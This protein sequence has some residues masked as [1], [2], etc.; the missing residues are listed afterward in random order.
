MNYRSLADLNQTI[1]SNLHKI[2]RDS[3]LVVGIPRSGLLAANI[4][5]LHRNRPLT[6][7]DG[8][9]TG[10]IF[11][12]GR[13]LPSTSM[14][15]MRKV[16]VIDDSINSG[17][18]IQRVK[19][20][21]STKNKDCDIKYCAIY[22]NS[23]ANDNVDYIFEACPHPRVFEWNLLNSCCLSN[24][25]MDID[26]V[27]CRDPT[28]DE[29]D[30]GIRY[31]EFLKSAEPYLLPNTTVGYLVTSRLEK[32]RRPTEQWLAS[33]DVKYKELFML[34]LPNKEARIASSAHAKFKSN[35]YEKTAAQLFVE[36]S[37]RQAL[38][39]ADSS[40]KPVLCV[41]INKIVYPNASSLAIAAKYR[42]CRAFDKRARFVTSAIGRLLNRYVSH[43]F[44]PLRTK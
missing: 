2:P 7:V 29:N 34:N 36:S 22:G 26:G 44:G 12:S 39:I 21:F 11:M 25:C 10:K 35:I 24:T 1:L 33:H 43:G 41:E 20:L 4:I 31:H 9:L 18:E 16:I 14:N 13:R 6:D 8:F 15:H 37:L 42:C 27:L 19:K 32:Y 3:D 28:E 30:D 17:F 23:K 5:A 40:G 38:N